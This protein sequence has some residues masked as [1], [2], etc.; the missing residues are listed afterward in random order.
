MQ[1][2][3]NL[4]TAFEEIR[5]NNLDHQENARRDGWED[6]DGFLC[7]DMK[8]GNRQ[9]RSKSTH[10]YIHGDEWMHTDFAGVKSDNNREHN[11]QTRASTIRCMQEWMDEQ[12]T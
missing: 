9:S 8:K 6:E 4:I 11:G 1:Q 10:A 3:G 12:G 7:L 5:K 2:L